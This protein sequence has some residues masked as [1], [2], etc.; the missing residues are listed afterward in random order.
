LFVPGP[1]AE[2][3]V[4][5]VEAAGELT[6]LTAA[7]FPQMYF[8][9]RPVVLVNGYEQHDIRILFYGTTLAQVAKLRRSIVPLLYLA[10]HLR[11]QNYGYVQ[12]FRE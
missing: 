2:P 10:I 1:V 9:C 12:F 6:E 5:A 7:L 8:R 3:G 11:Q 4:L